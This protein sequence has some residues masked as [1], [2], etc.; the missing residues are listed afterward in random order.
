MKEFFF[1]R[2]DHK[3]SWQTLLAL[4]SLFTF[5]ELAGVQA[6]SGEVHEL[7][8]SPKTIHWG[9]FDASIE[10]VLYISSG[11]SVYVETMV[12][13]GLERIRLAGIGDEEIPASIQAVEQG[14]TD[15]GPGAHPVTGPIY[16][17]GAEPGDVLEV[18]IIE[19]SPM[20]PY[21]V[22]GF[23]PGGGTLPERFP[24]GHL[25]VVRFSPDG[26]TAEIAEGVRAPLK[27]FFG[28][29]GVAPPLLSGRISSGPPGEHAGN[30]DLKELGVGATLYLPVHVPGGLLSIGDG[31]ALQGD[32]EVSGTAAE[33]FLSG[34]VKVTLHKYH[35]S[36]E[37]YRSRWPRAETPSHYITIGLHPDLDEAA[38]L[39]TNEMVDFLVGEKQ[40]SPEDAYIVCSLA[41]DLR[42]T[43]LVDGTKG[44]HAM[45]AKSI[46]E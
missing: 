2:F 28:T 3:K 16:V 37:F 31:H 5:V 43:Q 19:I 6:Q 8:L 10:P 7:R 20:V 9:Y 24:Y 13:R 27:P 25:A 34:T 39:A 44:V 33:T 45:I 30:L 11:D 4:M 18:S 14:V 15:R 23:L 36:N 29:I 26:Q 40:M 46:F 1:N 38:R 41:V 42:V 21:G 35:E 17:N 32:G 12:A 22:S